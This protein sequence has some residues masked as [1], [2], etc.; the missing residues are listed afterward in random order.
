MAGTPIST[1]R[2]GRIPLRQNPIAQGLMITTIA[3]LALG[4]VMV[5]SAVASVARPGAWYARLDVRHTVFA[6]LAM[7]ILLTLWR[8]DYRRFAAREGRWPVAAGVLLGVSL[9]CAAAVYVP[10]VGH[11]V[12]GYRR[13][14]RIGPGQYAI[15][16]QPSELLKF[17]LI[18]FLAA[19]LTR[20]GRDVRSFGRMFLPAAALTGLCLLLIIT[21]DFSTA[22]VVGLAAGVAMLL[23]GVPLA[24]LAALVVPAAGAFYVLVLRSPYRMARITAMFDPWAY[25]NPSTYQPRQSLLAI[26]HGGWTGRGVGNGMLKLGYLPEAPTDF[27]FSVYC[28]EW[29]FLGA[30][31]LMGLL[32]VWMWHVRRAAVRA[33]DRFGAVLAGTLGFAIVAQALLHIAVDLVAAPPTGMGMPF[34]SA[35]GTALLIM[36]AAV[37][38][39]I[40]VTSHNGEAAAALPS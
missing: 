35:G 38:M 6:A 29:G 1:D 14:L 5:H 12:G 20:P 39:I 8:V 26:V 40:S 36:A 4:V 21:Q 16:F 19:F 3:L 17:A 10:G 30:M 33:G 18:V 25:A 2:A 27:I 11:S 7:V 9:L 31:L 23:A 24:Y 37:A 13:W 15:G 28:E 32:C 22:V 34:L